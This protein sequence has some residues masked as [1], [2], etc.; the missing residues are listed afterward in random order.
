MAILSSCHQQPM[1]FEPRTGLARHALSRQKSVIVLVAPGPPPETKPAIRLI[2]CFH[3]D[4][5]ALIIHPETCF[6]TNEISTAFAASSGSRC[7][8]RHHRDNCFAARSIAVTITPALSTF[9]AA[10]RRFMLWIDRCRG[11]VPDVAEM[12]ISR[13]LYHAS[14]GEFRCQPHRGSRL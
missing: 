5:W 4:L 11:L 6:V 8:N 13:P 10:V 12:K 3:H 9:L 14:D 7:G 1:L 2:A